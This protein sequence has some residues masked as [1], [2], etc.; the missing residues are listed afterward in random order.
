M[1]TSNQ[2]C[3]STLLWWM[4]SYQHT[5]TSQH[6]TVFSFGPLTTRKTLRCWSVSKEEQQS[7]WRV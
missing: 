1:K 7:W 4:A 5:D 6:N 3:G 2:G